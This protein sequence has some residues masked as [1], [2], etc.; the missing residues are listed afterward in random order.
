MRHQREKTTRIPSFIYTNPSERCTGVA[1]RKKDVLIV[2]KVLRAT[3]KKKNHK[4]KS[5]SSGRNQTR[6]EQDSQGWKP[7]EE[8]GKDLKKKKIYLIHPDFL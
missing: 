7:Q 3:R 5:D 6:R 2:L 8:F 1:D 4:P